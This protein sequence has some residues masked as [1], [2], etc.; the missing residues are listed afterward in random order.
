MAARRYVVLLW[1]VSAVV[2]SSSF[3]Q[4]PGCY[5]KPCIPGWVLYR[6]QC[7]RVTPQKLPFNEAETYCQGFA[8]RNGKAHLASVH[9]EQENDFIVEL[10]SSAGIAGKDGWVWIGLTDQIVEGSF[11]WTDGTALS[12]VNWLPGAPSDGD[13][14]AVRPMDKQWNDGYGNKRAMC[15]MP[16]FDFKGRVLKA[17]IG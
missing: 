3:D 1:L 14:T 6:D 17:C 7:Y 5:V 15:K 12:Y 9:D 13:Y 8:N 4:V 10:A 16:S 2:P 11:A